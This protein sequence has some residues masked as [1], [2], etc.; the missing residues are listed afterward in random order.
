MLPESFLLPFPPVGQLYLSRCGLKLQPTATY[1]YIPHLLYWSLLLTSYCNN[2][3][4]PSLLAVSQTRVDSSI[5][6]LLFVDREDNLHCSTVPRGQAFHATAPNTAQFLPAQNIFPTKLIRINLS[7]YPK[8]NFG[9]N[10]L[11]SLL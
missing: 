11:I 7:R 1:M 10:F 5:T 8:T 2:N 3:K 6:L 4:L 9:N